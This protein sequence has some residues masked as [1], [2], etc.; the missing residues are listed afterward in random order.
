MFEIFGSG[1]EAILVG[2]WGVKGDE[3]SSAEC[4]SFAAEGELYHR[5]AMAV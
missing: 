4:Y 1:S 3:L 2:N 5:R